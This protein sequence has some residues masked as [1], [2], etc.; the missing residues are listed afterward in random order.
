VRALNCTTKLRG[1]P[2]RLVVGDPL[3]TEKEILPPAEVLQCCAKEGEGIEGI[4][5]VEL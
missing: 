4:V 2:A 5:E 3:P 1:L